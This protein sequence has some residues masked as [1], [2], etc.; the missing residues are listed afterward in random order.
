M[1]DLQRKRATLDRLR[2]KKAREK[3]VEV[4]LPLDGSGAVEKAE[5]LFRSIGSAEYDRLV[6]QF[7]PTPAQKKEGSTY[8]LDKF[9]PALLAN[10]CVDPKMT[11]EEAEELWTSDAWNRGELFNLFREA[12]DLCVT[13]ISVDPTVPASE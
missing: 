7:P 3:T 2:S 1:A 4:E 6:T 12:V 10:V 9:A 11:P 5:L 13:G 8:N